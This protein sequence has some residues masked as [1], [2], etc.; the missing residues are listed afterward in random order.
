MT[1]DTFSQFMTKPTY[2]PSSARE[3]EMPSATASPTDGECS[4]PPMGSLEFAT[5]RDH[6]RASL[7]FR[8]HTAAITTKKQRDRIIRRAEKEARAA[9]ER[10]TRKRGLNQPFQLK[11]DAVEFRHRDDV[12]DDDDN[13][14][15][16]KRGG[17]GVEAYPAGA[18]R[19]AASLLFAR[20]INSRPGLY[21]AIN[22]GGA[23]V[24]VVDVADAAMLDRLAHVWREVLFGESVRLMDLANDP[25]GR[26]DYFDGAF[27]VVKERP[28]PTSKSSIDVTVLSML[29]FAL[30]TIA[31]SPLGHTHLPEALNNAATDRMD[32]PSLDAATV[33]RTVRI[34]TGKVCRAR[35]EQETMKRIT[36][37]D[38]EVAVRFDRTPEQCLSELRRLAA[39]KE[40][41]K[42]SRELTL[43]QL[44][45]LGAAREWAIAA[46]AD[47]EAWKR[48]EISWSAVASA[49]AL[50]GPP[51]CGKTTFAAVFAAEAGLN[52]I[53]ATLA[54]WQSSGEAHLGHLLRAMRQDFDA[55]RAL[56]PS[57]LF[58][59]EIDSFPD[60]AGITHSHRDYVV[61]VVNALL[62]EI[63]GISGRDGVVV[64]GCSNDIGRCDPALLRAGRLERIVQIGLPDIPDLEKMFRV[65][66]GADL[67]GE[68]LRLVA[69]LAVGMTGADVERA[70]KDARRAARQDGCRALVFDDLRKAL[71]EE[72][73]RPAEQRWRTCIHEAAHIVVDVIHFGPENVF[74]RVAKMQ[75]Q[76]G[77]SARRH[78]GHMD[79]TA[80]EYR[81][82]I[83]LI[84]AGRT[85][86]ELLFGAPSH[87]SGGVNG[88][89]LDKATRLACAMIG[90]YGLSGPSPLVYLG[91][92]R[93]STDFLSFPEI[94]AAVQ[95]ELS[96]AARSCADLLK[97]NRAALEAAARQLAVQGRIDGFQ[98]DA[99]I[100]KQ[101]EE[102]GLS[103]TYDADETLQVQTK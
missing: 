70:V 69:E 19:V 66:L 5:Y 43:S 81:K 76:F 33:V 62:A 34:V 101:D 49:V 97:A 28:K 27:L 11:S 31:I 68:D 29:A 10:V 80:Q 6:W 100:A 63:D 15:S 90:S 25:V 13:L 56:A 75:G 41:K 91:P 45:G 74:A 7:R 8:L 82:R 20:M 94:R 96:E 78:D 36:L 79:G 88:S 84:L 99:L 67:L 89:D 85:A 35:I 40:T 54:K 52:F 14:P 102:G 87:G 22:D 23:P 95:R 57:C 72:D 3:R 71:V 86:E 18:G 48:G 60:R 12:E 61:E 50:S 39:A 55:A 77:I 42:K 53:S 24:V 9:V 2:P 73:D 26:R 17:A 1:K 44:H 37:A 59:D 38:M 32:F 65:R 30:P 4:P 21:D 58:I 64:I 47:I 46:I 92:A 98:V 51:G 103:E 83:E 93:D 16:W